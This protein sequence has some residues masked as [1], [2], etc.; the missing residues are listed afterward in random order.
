MAAVLSQAGEFGF[1][2]FGAMSLAGLIDGYQ[3]NLALLGIGLSMA[4]TPLLVKIGDQVA[5]RLE[6]RAA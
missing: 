3:F 5:E 6:P 1:V 2:L 4:A